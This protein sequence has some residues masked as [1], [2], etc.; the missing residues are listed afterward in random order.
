MRTN[1]TTRWNH[2]DLVS[3]RQSLWWVEFPR[4]P[5]RITDQQ[6]DQ[7]TKLTVELRVC[8]E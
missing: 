2:V 7:T 5:Y 6:A 8:E 1:E 3:R 4:H